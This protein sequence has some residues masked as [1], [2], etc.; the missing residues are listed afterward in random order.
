MESPAW[1]KIQANVEMNTDIDAEISLRLDAVK[2][3]GLF[4]SAKKELD[5]VRAD[6]RNVEQFYC[7][8]VRA[9]D[10]A[11]SCEPR[12]MPLLYWH[13]FETQLRSEEVTAKFSPY[14]NSCTV[15]CRDSVSEQEDDFCYVSLDVDECDE[16]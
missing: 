14:L 1:L 2:K 16:Q 12:L 10:D 3:N 11:F 5:L 6:M 9:L 8:R 7:E 15:D 13:K 4:L